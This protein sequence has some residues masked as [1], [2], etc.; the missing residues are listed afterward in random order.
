MRNK[1]LTAAFAKNVRKPGRYGD[2]HGGHGLT[3][4]VKVS[5]N[6]RIAKSWIQRIRMN[7]KPTHIG[8]G[9]YPVITLALARDKANENARALTLGH[10][11]RSGL[12]E[13][14]VLTT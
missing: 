1:P 7:G 4:D 9:A 12:T 11:P 8:L 5:R 2:G 10:D 6:G 13:I 14:P 3:L